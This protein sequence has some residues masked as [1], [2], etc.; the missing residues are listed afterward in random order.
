MSDFRL[1]QPT[2]THLQAAR[3]TDVPVRSL[4]T[5]RDGEHPVSH[6]T[7]LYFAQRILIPHT[8][9][10][11]GNFRGNQLLGRSMSLSPLC[12]TLTNDLHVS[13]GASVHHA[14]AGLRYSG[15]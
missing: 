14:F 15:V 7:F 1:L 12:T 6:H 3:T 2:L 13:T 8:S 10:P 4:L 5:R 11:E 9:D